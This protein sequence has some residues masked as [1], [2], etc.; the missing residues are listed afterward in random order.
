MSLQDP[1]S[2]MLTRIRNAQSVKKAFVIMDSSK[3]K[4]SIVRVLKE[5]GY[6]KNYQVESNS[7]KRILSLQLKYFE[8]KSVIDELKR[9]SKPSLRVYAS[10]KEIPSV[11]NGLGVAV[12][13][14]PKGIMT[15]KKAKELN[16]GG[17]ILCTVF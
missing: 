6:I 13:S 7:N 2:D 8:D 12:I 9:I 3:L 14:T 10:A 15:G 1:I 16:V 4:E 11:R 17:E 5:E